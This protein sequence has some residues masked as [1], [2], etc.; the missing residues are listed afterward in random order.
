MLVLCA[1]KRLDA[2]AMA[3]LKASNCDLGIDLVGILLLKLKLGLL[4]NCAQQC[5]GFLG[6]TLRSSGFLC[7]AP[8]ARATCDR[9]AFLK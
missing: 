8:E 4:L 3:R 2:A 6:V 9:I 7:T 5:W 1:D